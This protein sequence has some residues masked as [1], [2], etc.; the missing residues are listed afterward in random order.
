MAQHKRSSRPAAFPSAALGLRQS[1]Q[2]RA[3]A[4]LT[5]GA[6][7][8]GLLVV[9]GIVIVPAVWYFPWRL[10]SDADYQAD[11]YL[12][13]EP[14]G[15]H[16]DDREY[17]STWPEYDDPLAEPRD[18]SQLLYPIDPLDILRAPA[19][20]PQ[21]GPSP[22]PPP[23]RRDREP[24]RFTEEEIVT[25]AR[26][27]KWLAE[28]Q[29]PDGSWSYDHRLAP[30]CGG[31][32]RHPGSWKDERF[33]A[34]GLALLAFL[35]SGQT[36]K[37]G[38]Y[39]KHVY[40]AL[41]WLVR[42]MDPK[43]GQMYRGEENMEAH[44]I[45]T[46]ALCEACSMTNDKSL[47]RPARKAIDFILNAQDPA[48]GG[49]GA[50][51]R[52]PG[53]IDVTGWQLLALKSARMCYIRI[54][55][56]TVAAVDN[57]ANSVQTHSA[58]RYRNTLQETKRAADIDDRATTAIGLLCRMHVGWKK[59]NDPI[60]RG[61]EF[62]EETGPAKTD[63]APDLL[64]NFFAAQVLHHSQADKWPSFNSR[65]RESLVGA[66][67]TEGHETGSWMAGDARGVAQGGRHYV[68]CLNCMALDVYYR[69]LP[70]YK[71]RATDGD[72][73]D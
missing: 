35:G 27:L 46:L 73:E 57:F 15:P 25:V 48:G 53:R 1:V 70:V 37:D 6:L 10:S 21:P 16:L 69:W 30:K 33:G 41:S 14:D 65:L 34:T 49:W 51:P 44:G 60:A 32:C 56:H 13:I 12:R 9:L 19:P 71:P 40:N 7:H 67:A 36:H 66:Q 28:H 59:D 47:L 58:A 3:P 63:A 38:E 42:N 24:R 18:P 62:L 31:R 72:F 55:W 29:L 50:T 22:P 4:W 68:T 2:R 5:S 43:T 8:A 45:A 20:A 26:S 61:I 39:K 52:A 64:Y 54:P 11:A 23:T 17:G